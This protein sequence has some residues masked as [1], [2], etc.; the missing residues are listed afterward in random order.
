MSEIYDF[1]PI[2]FFLQL[3]WLGILAGILTARD[4]Y[5]RGIALLTKKNFLITAIQVSASGV[6]IS[7]M[8]CG[9]LANAVIQ[10]LGYIFCFAISLK[11]AR[12]RINQTLTS[13]A[14]IKWFII[15]L[16]VI[17][18][19]QFLLL[20]NYASMEWFIIFFVLHAVLLIITIIYKNILKN[21]SAEKSKVTNANVGI[22]L[23]I[24]LFYV[25]ISSF[26]TAIAFDCGI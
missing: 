17:W 26:A 15:F 8:I 3:S 10:T 9:H 24:Y 6:L 21:R 4:Q 12:Q 23:C 20:F 22:A 19:W 13:R 25:Q 18:F 1:F 5:N 2:L 11:M 7:L 14:W 16:A